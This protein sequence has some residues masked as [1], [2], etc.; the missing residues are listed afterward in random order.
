MDHPFESEIKRVAH[1]TSHSKLHARWMHK[2]IC[3]CVLLL[4]VVVVLIKKKKVRIL[5]ISCRRIKPLVD[6]QI[7]N[8]S[9]GI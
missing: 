3:L 6:I 5:A 1:A 9:F 7:K 8:P 2:N 4:V